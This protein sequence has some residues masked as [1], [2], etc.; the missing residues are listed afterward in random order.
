MRAGLAAILIGAA[1][2][3][4]L[5][6]PALVLASSVAFL[7]SEGA[8]MLVFTPLQKKGLVKAAFFSSLVGLVVDS[9]IFLTLAFGSLKYLQGQVAGKLIMVLIALPLIALLRARDE[10]LGLTAA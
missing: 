5:A 10:R 9:V 1:I 7:L 3:A 2:S 4:F 8:D 6:P